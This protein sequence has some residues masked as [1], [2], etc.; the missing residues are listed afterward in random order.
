M[1]IL[2]GALESDLEEI[3][4]FFSYITDFKTFVAFSICQDPFTHPSKEINNQRT[5]AEH[6]SFW[7]MQ[8]TMFLL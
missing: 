5:T 6:V 2:L 7:I 1:F 8:V 4:N 3:V